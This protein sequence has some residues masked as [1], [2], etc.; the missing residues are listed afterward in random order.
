MDRA[1]SSFPGCDLL[2]S[3]TLVG[4]ANEYTPT[5][6][7]YEYPQ[8]HRLSWSA[9]PPSTTRKRSIVSEPEHIERTFLQDVSKRPILELSSIRGVIEFSHRPEKLTCP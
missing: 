1:A 4:S 5:G 7:S 2:I 8:P 9:I 3:A 6:A